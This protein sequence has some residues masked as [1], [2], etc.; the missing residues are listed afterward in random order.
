MKDST[1][2]SVSQKALGEGLKL[3]TR[4]NRDSVLVENSTE[5]FIPF[6]GKIIRDIYVQSIGFEKSIYG[7]E[8]EF[9]QKVGRTANKLHINTREKTIRQHLFIHPNER[10]NPYKLSDNERFLREKNFILDSRFIVS[11]IENSDSVDIII[12]TRDV[13]SIGF[14][15]GGSFPSAPKLNLYDANLS[16]RGQRIEFNFLIDQDRTPKTGYGLSFNKSSFLGSFTD[17]EFFYSQLNSGVSYG[18]EIEYTTGVLL[19]R[20]LV[21]PYS[22]M[23]WGAQWSKNWSKNVY[24]RPDSIFLDYSYDLVDLWAGYNF[25]ANKKIQDRNRAFIALRVFDG[26]YTKRPDSEELLD[27]RIYNNA[28]GI[29]TA[30]TFY[31]RD[32]YKTQYVL[33][34]GRTEDVPYGYS[35]SA[36]TGLVRQLR[37]RRPYAGLKFEYSNAF[38]SGNFYQL[39]LNTSSYLR[40][41]RFED[42]AIS[43]SF[44]FFTKAFS[45][46]KYK[47]RN[48]FTL[49]STQLFNVYANDW[50]EINSLII[51]GLRVREL[52]AS[53]RNVAGIS[54]T[55]YTPWSLLGFR[56]APFGEF[57]WAMMNCESC[58]R[59][60]NIFTG[61]S[62]GMR[63]R[64]ENLIFGTIEIKATYISNDE[65]GNSKVRL[66]F[67]QNL[68]FKKIDSFVT[69][70]SL[71]QYNN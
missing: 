58:E 7:N 39:E 26:Y 43:F 8:K 62:G 40:N 50:L 33:G 32:F 55:L 16:G 37:T 38:S 42:A 69:A 29:L 45:L 70:P 41:S 19:D 14:S 35:L 56:I 11:P 13:F 63:I 71:N 25:G 66:T 57:K 17:L 68:R 60:S 30:L 52:N 10:L 31:K 36:T 15:A 48:S 34:F 20:A 64:N 18:D 12:V 24:S 1:K 61:L 51:P 27:A 3:I 21:S 54:S 5:K 44:A 65:S 46:G 22:R 6:E 28:S 23:A 4:S 47:I 49:G 9:S 67:R 2:V 53:S 59:E